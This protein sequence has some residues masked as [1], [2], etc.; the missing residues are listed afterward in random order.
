MFK[1]EMAKK[2]NVHREDIVL[3]SVTNFEDDGGKTIVF[4][5]NL[6][7]QAKVADSTKCNEFI[8]SSSSANYKYEIILPVVAAASGLVPEFDILNVQTS[9]VSYC[10]GESMVYCTT[11]NQCVDGCSTCAENHVLPKAKD[12]LTLLAA[13]DE[14][15]RDK[16]EEECAA[17]GNTY[18]PPGATANAY[19]CVSKCS[20]CTGYQRSDT[21]GTCLK[22]KNE[23]I[24][25]LDNKVLCPGEASYS[26]NLAYDCV[27]NCTSAKCVGFEVEPSYGE[28]KCSATKTPG[29]CQEENQV[30]C[31]TTKGCV[32]KCKLCRAY[33]VNPSGKDSN[34]CKMAQTATS[35]KEIGKQFCPSDATE[36]FNECLDSCASCTGKTE[37][38]LVTENTNICR[39]TSGDAILGCLAGGSSGDSGSGSEPVEVVPVVATKDTSAEELEARNLE[40][41]AAALFALA[42][43]LEEESLKKTAEAEKK[44]YE[45]AYAKAK[46]QNKNLD[47][48]KEVQLE[49]APRN[50]GIKRNGKKGM[51]V[52]WEP[53]IAKEMESA[54]GPYVIHAS[55]DNMFPPRNRKQ[56]LYPKTTLNAS[57]SMDLP[58]SLPLDKKVVYVRIRLQ[59]SYEYSLLTKPWTVY[60]NCGDSHY[61]DDQNNND[62]FYSWKCV[63]CPIGARCPSGSWPDARS[64]FW[65]VTWEQSTQDKFQACPF[66]ATCLVNESL[67]TCNGLRNSTCGY[68]AAGS[69]GVMCAVC[70]DGYARANGSCKKCDP[71]AKSSSVG[72]QILAAVFLT[73]F[74]IISS[75]ALAVLPA[76][77][78]ARQVSTEAAEN[79]ET[80]DGSMENSELA[81]QVIA[82]SMQDDEDDGSISQTVQDN[83]Q[84][85]GGDAG[86]QY[87]NNNPSNNSSSGDVM[88]IQNLESQIKVA[89]GHLQV[90]SALN[91]TFDIKWPANFDGLLNFLKIFNIDILGIFQPFSPCAFKMSF[92]SGFYIHMCMLPAFAFLLVM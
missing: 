35:C 55:T 28:N 12:R 91:V 6:I 16:T 34:S 83:V 10:E 85:A 19:D 42:R 77:D 49:G 50:I 64:G 79:G 40:S 51:M 26:T 8:K 17:M 57:I 4:A 24:C 13:N 25:A 81:L 72:F 74:F 18:C 27:P 37:T 41:Q 32:A 63:K 45:R 23:L 68:C 38:P 73:L 3:E 44:A 48:L 61:F 80:A 90:I 75:V 92:L 1:Q 54:T 59:P 84:G 15:Q 2:L 70:M 33:G 14:C 88:A 9:C 31:P 20:T 53:P 65:K 39:E 66:P 62:N 76:N 43:R 5:I 11:S 67:K 29:I 21:T 22:N 71:G 89:I 87:V 78:V 56:L 30:Y 47:N 69:T 46:Q 36:R 52:T 7:Y 60:E 82:G 58:D 86:D